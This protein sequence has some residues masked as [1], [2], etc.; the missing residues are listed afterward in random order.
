M[1]RT[2]LAAR[3]VVGGSLPAN[4]TPPTIAGTV[5]LAGTSPTVTPG[6]WSGT[7]SLTYTYLRDGVPVGGLTGVSL[8][9]I[10]AHVFVAADIGCEIDAVEEDS[11][12]ATDAMTP[13]PLVYD[14]ATRLATC[15]LGH[16]GSGVTTVSGGLD[17]AAA[18]HG[19]FAITVTAPSSGARP[20]YS[21][22]G[23]VGSRPVST[24]DGTDDVLFGTFSSGVGTMVGYGLGYAGHRVAFGASSDVSVGQ[25]N[26]AGTSHAHSLQDVSASAWRFG[27]SGGANL[28]ATSDPD[29]V[30]AVYS[31]HA[32]SGGS[33]FTYK[34]NV[35]ESTTSSTTPSRAEPVSLC[36][37][38]RANLT[39]F[40]NYA[41]QAWM[42]WATAPTSTERD[43]A[44]AL[45]KYLT[46]IG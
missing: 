19:G 21:A 29:G 10:N 36:L 23:G 17:T 31:G 37:F 20:A 22:T 34:N 3:R 16:M 40:G 25:M 18:T 28:N 24:G 33:Y 26:A 7:P 43:E 38:G 9:T 2:I 6:T 44:H 45:I 1:S 41:I 11:V 13:T 12:S 32:N 30:D 42:V 14:D 15:A 46:G 4:I 27:A 5:G 8:A 39:F 35:Q